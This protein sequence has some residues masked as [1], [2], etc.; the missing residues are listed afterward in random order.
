MTERVMPTDGRRGLIRDIAFT[1]RAMLSESDRLSQA[2]A[3]AHGMS[4]S[5]FRALLHVVVAE[6]EGTPLA[7]SDLRRRLNV[8]VGAV[9]YIIDRLVRSGHVHRE[10]HPADRRKVILRYSEQGFHL[11]QTY[12]AP[13]GEQYRDALSDLPDDDLS[14]AER[15]LGALLD[16]M[17]GPGTPA[18]NSGPSDERAVQ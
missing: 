3:S 8:S 17:R 7:A 12:F 16:A 5:D 11:A 2:F 14:C 15:V 13:I 18:A 4:V 9:T 1:V 10:A 6:N